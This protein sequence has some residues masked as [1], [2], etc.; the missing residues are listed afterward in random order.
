MNRIN[1][2]IEK[3]KSYWNA[4][5]IEKEN[6]DFYD[7]ALQPFIDEHKDCFFLYKNFIRRQMKTGFLWQKIIGDYDSF[8]DLEKKHETGLDVVSWERKIIIE[9]KNRYNTDNSSSRKQNFLKLA[10]FKKTHPDFKC[11]YAVINENKNSDGKMKIIPIDNVEIEY[12]S[13]NKLMD[14]IFGEDKANIL[15]IIQKIC[16]Q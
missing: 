3:Y 15:N 1:N 13:G 11:I 14:F 8:E 7:M 6:N 12:M 9:L 2:N 4:L 10:A 16:C 5:P